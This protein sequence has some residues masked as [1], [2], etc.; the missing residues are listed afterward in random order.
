MKFLQVKCGLYDLLIDVAYII[1]ITSGSEVVISNV[2]SSENIA[3]GTG[4]WREKTIE[5]IDMTLLFGGKSESEDKVIIIEAVNELDNEEIKLLMIRVNEIEDIIDYENQTLQEIPNYNLLLGN[6][7]S[8]VV[9]SRNSGS[10]LFCL[11][12]PIRTQELM[13]SYNNYTLKAQR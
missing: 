12:L 3:S 4:V 8:S 13:M 9:Y 10:Y 5:F 7:V 6:L 1:E 2:G 11:R